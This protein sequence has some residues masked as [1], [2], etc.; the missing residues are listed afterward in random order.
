M[1]K[2]NYRNTFQINSFLEIYVDRVVIYVVYIVV[3]QDYAENFLEK[4]HS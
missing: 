2:V 3:Y 4:H 1:T